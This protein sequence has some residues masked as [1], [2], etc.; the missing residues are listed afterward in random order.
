M[1]LT[2]LQNL[3]LAH[4]GMPSIPCLPSS[5][6]CLDFDNNLNYDRRDATYMMTSYFP[7]LRR[8]SIKGDHYLDSRRLLALL[9][10]SKGKLEALK[11][12][13]WSQLIEADIQ[14]HI[15]AG[16]LDQVTELSL[17]YCHVEDPTADLLA[18]TCHH[19]KSVDLS[20]SKITGCGLKALV[21]K[22]R[23]KLEHV[24]LLNCGSVSI[25]AV[26]FARS[27]G[28]QVSYYFPRYTQDERNVRENQ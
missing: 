13:N 16:F 23:G 3:R 17:A 18:S 25:D 21:L 10:P 9:G 8:L 15:Q 14:A 12:E 2:K 26:E 6:Q 4:N 20:Y 27:R 11:I 7:E 19:L 5:L 22:P 1:I 28:I 24:K